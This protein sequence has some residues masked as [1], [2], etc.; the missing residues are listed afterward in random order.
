MAGFKTF[1]SATLSSSD[2]NGYLMRQAVIQCTSTTR[3]SSPHE[4][5]VVF[6]TDTEA[7]SF[8]DGSAWRTLLD[9]AWRSFTPSVSFG[10][11]TA[12]ITSSGVYRRTASTQIDYEVTFSIS[13]GNG[14]TGAYLIFE[15][16][17]APANEPTNVGSCVGSGRILSGARWSVDVY[18]SMDTTKT[19]YCGR[20][21]DDSDVGYGSSV[22]SFG[23]YTAGK[24][25]GSYRTAT[26]G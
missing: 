18:Y 26:A 1:T 19:A 21:S 15:L 22:W 23:G 14:M 13:A 20:K 4:G 17:F 16:P 25:S 9:T 8:H 7:Y 3:P 10:G 6:E 12:Y 2:V 24:F 11:N 5:M